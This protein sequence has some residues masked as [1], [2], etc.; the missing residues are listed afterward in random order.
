MSEWYS[1]YRFAQRTA[2]GDLY[3]TDMVLYYLH[4]SIRERGAAPTI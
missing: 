1:G 4:E 2:A 3:N